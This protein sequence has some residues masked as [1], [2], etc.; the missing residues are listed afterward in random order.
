[1]PPK[2]KAAGGGRGQAKKVATETAVDVKEETVGE[3]EQRHDEGESRAAADNDVKD[4]DGTGANGQASDASAF[5]AIIADGSLAK[6][7]SDHVT[8]RCLV[9]SGTEVNQE[10]IKE[11]L[12]EVTLVTT[13]E[14]TE[15]S[16]GVVEKV[17]YLEGR[18]R[19][20]AAAVLTKLYAQVRVRLVVSE[21]GLTLDRDAKT[22]E[23]NDIANEHDISVSV[24]ALPLPMSNDRTITIR[25][26]VGV[27][28]GDNGSSKAQ[29]ILEGVQKV[30]QKAHALEQT[31]ESFPHIEYIPRPIAGLYGHPD[32][33][34]RQVINNQLAELNPYTAEHSE[35]NPEGTYA[36]PSG[37]G[38]GATGA[39]AGAGA[40][41][42][43]NDTP[44]LDSQEGLELAQQQARMQPINKTFSQ[45]VL[46]PHDMVGSIIGKGGVKVNEIRQMSGSTIK[47]NDSDRGVAVNRTITV[48]GTP[49]G[50]QMALMLM[51]QRIESERQI[52][53]AHGRVRRD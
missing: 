31:P 23:L 12:P 45:S 32:T 50:N 3:V 49:E 18:L 2:R 37:P 38:A 27:S 35:P 1:M 48:T 10:Q 34:R 24:S 46:V 26:V 53:M 21:N 40:G 7:E 52:Q 13:K 17:V 39:G 36:L 16:V 33:F 47:I 20:V 8:V 22:Q 5:E 14:P 19:S 29:N 42:P 15:G 51:Y 30:I 43:N 11:V 4:V 25:G 44:L 6:D 28:E 9:S 41:G